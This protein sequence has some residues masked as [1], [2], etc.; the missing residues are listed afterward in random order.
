MANDGFGLAPIKQEGATAPFDHFPRTSVS[1][2]E[3][4]Y[5]ERRVPKRLADEAEVLIDAWLISRGFDPKE[6]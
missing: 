1:D 4:T 3:T 6:I 2:V 5:V